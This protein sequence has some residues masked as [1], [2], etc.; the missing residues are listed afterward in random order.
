M[1]PAD[2]LEATVLPALAVGQTVPWNIEFDAITV[3]RRILVYNPEVIT[4][5]VIEQLVPGICKGVDSLRSV[6]AKN[7]VYCTEDLFLKCGPELN[8][9]QKSVDALAFALLD[10]CASNTPKP[11][12]TAALSALN[13]AVLTGP[14]PKLAPALASRASHKNHDVAEN[15]MIFAERAL[16]SLESGNNS[17]F[18]NVRSH[19]TYT[20]TYLP[21]YLPT[22]FLTFIERSSITYPHSDFGRGPSFTGSQLRPQ[23]QV[24]SC[25]KSRAQLLRRARGLAFPF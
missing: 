5:K 12:K 25:Q 8:L 11:L 16:K 19:H 14:L 20:H 13:Q 4:S 10:S 24:C 1:S 9:S 2:E 21:T 17:L 18:A 7:A 3:L 15:A 22:F 6:L 23:R